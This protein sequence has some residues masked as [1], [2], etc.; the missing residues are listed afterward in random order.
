MAHKRKTDADKKSAHY[1][2]ED[3]MKVTDDIFSLNKEN[4]Y[5]PGAFIHGLVFAL[6]VT[7][8]SYNIP[9]QQI[10]DLRRGCRKYFKEVANIKKVDKKS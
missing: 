9:H 5:N 7:Q 2:I 10:A 1:K 8:Q 3:A 4:E 6:E